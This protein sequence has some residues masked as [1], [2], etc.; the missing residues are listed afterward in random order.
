MIIDKIVFINVDGV[1][2]SA[3]WWRDHNDSLVSPKLAALFGTVIDN[4]PDVKVVVMTKNKDTEALNIELMANG[5]NAE[6]VIRSD[7]IHSD[8]ELLDCLD[9]LT[10]NPYVFAIMDYN[11]KIYKNSVHHE[12]LVPRLVTTDYESGVTKNN[13]NKVLKLL[14]ISK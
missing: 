4:I 1:L 14:G 2:N 6:G 3:E 7:G 5:I 9:E 11:D 12:Q 10:L 8:I 13:I